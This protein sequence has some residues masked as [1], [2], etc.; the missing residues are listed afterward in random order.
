MGNSEISRP[1]YET[2]QSSLLKGKKAKVADEVAA[3]EVSLG[4]IKA[5][6]YA[7]K[8]TMKAAVI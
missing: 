1:K 5:Y 2:S 3:I 4:K 6:S 7:G 8:S